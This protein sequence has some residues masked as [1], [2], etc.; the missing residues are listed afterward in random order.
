MPSVS[1]TSPLLNLAIIG[2]LDLLR[3][4]LDKVHV[5]PAVIAEL[6]LDEPLPGCAAI[7]RAVETGW[8]EVHEV[9]D[10]ALVQV[11]QRELDRGEAEAIALALQ[12]K[13]D[14]LLL[15]ER[16]PQSGQIVQSGSHG[17]LGSPVA[18]QEPRTD[19]VAEGRSGTAA[20][21]GRVLD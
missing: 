8:I 12:M 19:R 20:A 10:E 6:R 4:Q 11:L 15:D 5:P 2:R 7:Q 3:Q 21:T 9:Q 18:S 13:A 14:R 1:N 16:S 17:R